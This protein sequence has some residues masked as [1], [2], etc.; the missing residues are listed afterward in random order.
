MR[1]RWPLLGALLLAGGVLAQGTNQ[2][3]NQGGAFY[4][5]SPLWPA[6]RQ[7][8]TPAGDP[9]AGLDVAQ[10]N[11]ALHARACVTCHGLDGHGGGSGAFP[12][13]AGQP[14]WYLY[15]TLQDYS[16]GRR[17]NAAMTPIAR[18]LT[19]RQMQDVAAWYASR[20]L[21]SAAAPVE[22]GVTMRQ[23]GGSL[24]AV[25]VPARGV[26]ACTNCHG[27]VG[28]GQAPSIPALAGQY[29]PYL[30]L[31]LRLWKQGARGGDP[32]DVMARIAAGMTEREID[33]VAAYYSGLR[34]GG[35]LAAEAGTPA[36][37]AA[38]V[39]GAPPPGG[40]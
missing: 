13:L 25:G 24:A 40:R 9:L 30:A 29:A 4:G 12:N 14:A 36:V 23:I 16:A 17:P 33:A 1:M 2:G 28:E 31:Q 32:L 11:D 7:A 20:P 15:K 21:V 18:A 26:S 37:P 19:D 27:A 34:P 38:A 6:P 10:G 5:M 8:A 3:A 35:G 22:A 39:T